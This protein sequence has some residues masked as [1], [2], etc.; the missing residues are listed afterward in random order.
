MIASAG[1]FVFDFGLYIFGLIMIFCFLVFTS[2]FLLEH[3]RI[4]WR[5]RRKERRKEIIKRY[6]IYKKK[7]RI[8]RRAI[9]RQARMENRKKKKEEIK[10]NKGL[11]ST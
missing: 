6:K 8:M 10:K 5:L 2:F 7:L 9:A 1:F 11:D 4:V 3:F